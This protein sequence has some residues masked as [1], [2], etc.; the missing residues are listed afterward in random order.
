MIVKTLDY[1]EIGAGKV[2]M[3]LLL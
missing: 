3:S 2:E 1:K